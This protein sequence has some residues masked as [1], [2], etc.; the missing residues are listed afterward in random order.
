MFLIESPHLSFSEEF[1]PILFHDIIFPVI[2][3][4]I[5]D[6][7][8]TPGGSYLRQPV[9]RN[10]IIAFTLGQDISDKRIKGTVFCTA[11]EKAPF[12]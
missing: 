12:C 8:T 4:F 7:V 6:I 2:F 5:D 11:L 9:G 1:F 10:L 3:T